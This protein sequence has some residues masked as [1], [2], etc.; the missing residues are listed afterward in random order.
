MEVVKWFGENYQALFL[1]VAGLVGVA[2][3]IVR[4]TP[5]QK[6]D[7][8]VERIGYYLRKIMDFL[9]IPNSKK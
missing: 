4:L 8:A 3:I 5:T 6:D 9:K 1:V 7:G 2:E